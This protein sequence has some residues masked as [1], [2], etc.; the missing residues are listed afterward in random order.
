[1][2]NYTDLTDVELLRLNQIRNGEY[3]LTLRTERNLTL[4]AV[5]SKLTVS[6]QYLSEIEKGNKLPSD[7]LLHELAQIYKLELRDEVELYH[8]YDRMPL[9]TAE[10]LKDQKSTHF[11]FAQL[12]Q[13]V[14]DGKIS[15]EQREEFYA[16]FARMYRGFIARTLP[17][18]A[19]NL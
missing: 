2:P 4:K 15:E 6:F 17:G 8:R 13:L 11:A 7:L 9:L 1:M 3:L 10:E 19:G 14:I 5:A 12:R 18:E 16:A